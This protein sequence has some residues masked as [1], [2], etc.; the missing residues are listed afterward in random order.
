MIL[1]GR[2]IGYLTKEKFFMAEV[3]P[4]EHDLWVGWENFLD[5]KLILMPINAVA[6][7]SYFVRSANKDESHERVDP[8]A[9]QQELLACCVLAVPERKVASLFR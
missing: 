3:D 4:G 5:P 1:D 2:I 6:G 8:A 7:Q 9:A